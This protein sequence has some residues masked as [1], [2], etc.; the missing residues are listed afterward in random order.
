MDCHPSGLPVAIML[1]EISDLILQELKSMQQDMNFGFSKMQ[2]NMKDM[3]SKLLAEVKKSETTNNVM[4]VEESLQPSNVETDICI[5]EVYS[6]KASVCRH[7]MPTKEE[8]L[9]DWEITRFDT[10]DEIAPMIKSI[11]PQSEI[12]RNVTIKDEVFDFENLNE[13]NSLVEFHASRFDK[14]TSSDKCITNKVK[15]SPINVENDKN[16]DFC[17][18]VCGKPFKRK[19]HLKAHLRS[20]TGERPYQCHICSKSFSQCSAL[21]RHMTIHT[22][23]RRYQCKVCCKSFSQNSHLQTHMTVHTGEC[24]YQCQICIKPNAHSAGH[25][26]EQFLLNFIHRFVLRDMLCTRVGLSG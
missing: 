17:C 19:A 10:G 2:E 26:I 3:Y 15:Q 12:E 7:L 9:Q 25:R 8:P 21:Q 24:P 20:H 23:V 1:K 16:K 13:R 11:V 18:S 4:P 14:C 5:E 22:G 6:E